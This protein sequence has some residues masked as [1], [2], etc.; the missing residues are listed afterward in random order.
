M[1]SLDYPRDW[2]FG[3][4][5]S[6]DGLTV[7]GAYR[8]LRKA[9]V[10]NPDDRDE[11]IDKIIVELELD[12]GEPVSVWLGELLR[13]GKLLNLFQ[14]ELERRVQLGRTD[15]EP[16]ERI[17]ITRSREQ[18]P[19]RTTGWQMWDWEVAFE[20]EAPPATPADLLCGT[21]A[22]AENV[23][24]SAVS[25]QPITGEDGDAVDRDETRDPVPF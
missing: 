4:K 20:H 12:D 5:S 1:Q 21:K 15:F 11:R 14:A 23:H 8:E 13:P 3:E 6:D 10:E 22:A 2:K 17:T 16:G 19:S 24:R 25:A 9:S 7:T 18:R